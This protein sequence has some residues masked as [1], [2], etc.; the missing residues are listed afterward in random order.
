MTISTKILPTILLFCLFCNA[1]FANFESGFRENNGQFKNQYGTPS[2]AALFLLN[3]NHYNVQLRKDG[4]S[5]DLYLEE[6]DSL[7]VNRV[8]FIFENFN[9]DYHLEKVE[10]NSSFN[11]GFGSKD[12]QYEQVVYKNFYN[13]IDIIFKINNNGSFEYDFLVHDI[14]NVNDIIFKINGANTISI[15]NGE[16]L[17]DTEN[18]SIVETIP[19]SYDLNGNKVD[20]NFEF[21]ENRKIKFST[22]GI[23]SNLI[24][25]P[26]PE[27][28]YATYLSNQWSIFDIKY[29]DNFD[30][31]I[32]GYTAQPNNIATEGS[33]Q[34]TL[35]GTAN[36]TLARF[37][38]NNELIW[39]TYFGEGLTTAEELVVTDNQ[40]V[41]CGNTN[42]ANLATS[43]AFQN[44]N[45]GSQDVFVAIFDLNGSLQHCTYLGGSSDDFATSIVSLGSDKVAICG[46]TNSNNFPTVSST[47]EYSQN[48]DGFISIYNLSTYNFDSSMIIGGNDLDVI[49]SIVPYGQDQ[50]LFI[51]RTYSAALTQSGITELPSLFHNSNQGLINGLVGSLNSSYELEFVGFLGGAGSNRLNFAATN[52]EGKIILVGSTVDSDVPFSNDAQYTDF[53]GEASGAIIYILHSDLSLEYCSLIFPPYS[54]SFGDL[55][56]DQN[57]NIYIVSESDQDNSITTPGSFREEFFHYPPNENWSQD[58]IILCLNPAG[59]KL[60]GTYFG[61]YG[62]DNIYG[63][64][65][66]ENQLIIAGGILSNQNFTE[67]YQYSITTSDAFNSQISTY[68]G[69]VAIFDTYLSTDEL[70]EFEDFSIYPNPA[71][72]RLN[73]SQQFNSNARYSI[74][75]LT[76]KL[77][78]QD[79]LKSSTLELNALERGV[80]FLYVM[81]DHKTFRKKFVKH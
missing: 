26:T 4:F 7:R 70:Q 31:I 47:F 75:D 50:L 2:T 76:G 78:T 5:Y 35:I 60:W 65:I 41:F 20:V 40:I 69:F 14:G 79:I 67:D 48:T 30:Y 13:G 55:V 22:G 34:S 18:N 81:D 73:L 16:I 80:Y 71:T 74:F 33:Y 23:K 56:L 46:R 61:N 32:L 11:L 8:D 53:N 1:L 27:L 28:V 17:I 25:D 66:R 51:G 45:G 49:E 62:P 59:I 52:S 72:D 54:F 42:G 9:E 68:S 36:A 38:S 64:D 21:A 3:C 12:F 15:E 44:S 29:L 10:F 19:A 39:S 58:G 63:V 43:G 24:I 6:G 77:V 37:N 57:D